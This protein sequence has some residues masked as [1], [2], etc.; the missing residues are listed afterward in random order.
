MRVLHLTTEFPPVIHGGLGTAVGGLALASARAGMTVGVLL[1]GDTEGVAYA[2]APPALAGAPP[3]RVGRASQTAGA[4][5]SSP[6]GELTLFTLA[7]A[8]AQAGAVR[9]VGAW[10]P[11]VIHLHSFWLWPV[12]QAIREQTGVPLVYTVH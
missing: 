6:P 12:A 4:A 5:H 3:Q 8:E 2:A 7:W 9:L 10:R 1:I 11:D